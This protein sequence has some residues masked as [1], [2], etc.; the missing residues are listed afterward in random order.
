MKFKRVIRY[1]VLLFFLCMIGIIWIYKFQQI[2]Q[3][4]P[5]AKVERYSCGK[6]MEYDGIQM[7]VNRADWISENEIKKNNWN[8]DTDKR[9][10]DYKILDFKTTITNVSEQ[11]KTLDLT[12][13][14]LEMSGFCNGVSMEAFFIINDESISSMILNL[15]KGESVSVHIPYML[16]QVSF[17]DKYWKN[18]EQKEAGITV[19]LYPVKRYMAG[20]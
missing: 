16:N 17:T 18:I 7:V 3:K 2:N 11:R 5:P 12:D 20:I 6:A 1:G 19:S 13:F 10:G 14:R 4:Y 9:L 15:E 8:I